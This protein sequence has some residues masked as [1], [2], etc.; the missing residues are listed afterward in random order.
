[1]TTNN[2]YNKQNKIYKSSDYTNWGTLKDKEYLR[3]RQI[4]KNQYLL[5]NGKIYKAIKYN[6][7]EYIIRDVETNQNFKMGWGLFCDL[8]KIKTI[9]EATEKRDINNYKYFFLFT[10]VEYHRNFNGCIYTY[11]YDKLKLKPHRT[12][13]KKLIK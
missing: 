12:P 4:E 9:E 11:D 7:D 5:Y 8:V 2:R 1:M 10:Q 3:W 13:K 6:E